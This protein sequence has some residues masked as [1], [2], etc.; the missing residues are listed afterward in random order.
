MLNYVFNK[1]LYILFKIACHSFYFFFCCLNCV[2]PNNCIVFHLWLWYAIWYPFCFFHW[3]PF[4][5]GI[6]KWYGITLWYPFS[7]F[8]WFVAGWVVSYTVVIFPGMLILMLQ[9]VFLIF[10]FLCFPWESHSC[11]LG[12]VYS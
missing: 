8:H 6:T 4:C 7:F 12:C 10:L 9:W 11:T 3:Y 5:Y 2:K 1:A